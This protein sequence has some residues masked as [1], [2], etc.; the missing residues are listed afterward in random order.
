MDHFLKVSEHLYLYTN[1]HHA[2]FYMLWCTFTRGISF[3]FLSN[4]MA[5]KNTFFVVGQI[6]PIIVPS[7]FAWFCRWGDRWHWCPV[8]CA[9]IM[10]ISIVLCRAM[11]VHIMVWSGPVL[12]KL[13]NISYC[14]KK[15][16]WQCSGSFKQKTSPLRLLININVTLSICRIIHMY[17]CKVGG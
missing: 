1:Y 11:C 15:A 17:V 8:V 14:S 5:K 16:V 12:L 10:A 6:N 4:K 13:Y 2:T 3:W 9:H 7:S